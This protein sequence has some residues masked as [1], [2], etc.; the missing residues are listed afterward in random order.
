MKVLSWTVIT[1]ER[2]DVPLFV[3]YEYETVPFPVPAEDVV[4]QDVAL[5]EADQGT[6]VQP[7]GNETLNVVVPLAEETLLLVGVRVAPQ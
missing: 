1:P 2:D 6:L 5:L 4:S 3:P 7:L